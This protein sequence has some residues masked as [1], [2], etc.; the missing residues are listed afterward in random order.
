MDRQVERLFGARV[1]GFRVARGLTQEWVAQWMTAA[2]YPM[3]QTTV[4]KL[5]NAGRPTPVSEVAA[6]ASLFEVPISEFFDTTSDVD[7]QT[8][9]NRT[10]LANLSAT[11][12][13]ELV[14]L[15]EHRGRLR[16]EFKATR[17][18]LMELT[19]PSVQYDPDADDAW[20]DGEIAIAAE[21]GIFTKKP[22]TD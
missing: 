22:V 11:Q 18:E 7:A 9:M 15:E 19:R 14:Q 20:L 13:R 5:E 1:K 21:K 4:A 16:R 2:G 17:A 12:F 3:H 10:R 6:L 8:T